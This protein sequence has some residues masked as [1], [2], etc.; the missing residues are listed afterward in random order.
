MRGA[1][2]AQHLRWKVEKDEKSLDVTAQS[3]AQGAPPFFE[4]EFLCGAA[5][6]CQPACGFLLRGEKC[7]IS[8]FRKI[9]R[10]FWLIDLG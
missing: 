5:G 1:E 10:F 8:R 3:D 6:T 2:L 4:V 7:S 9:P